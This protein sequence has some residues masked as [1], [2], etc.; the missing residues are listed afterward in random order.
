MDLINGKVKNLYYK[1][2]LASLGSALITS[3][4]SVVDMAVVGNYVGPNG[5]AALA[6][7]APIWNIIYSLGLLMGVGGSILFSSIRGRNIDSSNED[8]KYFTSSFIGSI[9]LAIICW[10]VFYLFDKPIL[11]FFGA[12]DETLLSLCESYLMPIKIVLPTYLI[13]QMLIA[14]LRNDNDPTLATFA[15]LFGGVFNVIGDILF[16]FTFNMGIFGAGLATAIGSVITTILLCIHFFKKKNT[17]K[18]I[19]IDKLFI[20][21]KNITINGFS[22]FFIDVAMGILTI[23][24]NRQI[25][26]YLDSNALS[27]YG[28]IINISTFVQCCAYGVGQAS[29]PIISTNYG[30]NNADRI[31]QTLKYALIT[32]LIFSIF[33][34]GISLIY[35][36]GFIYLFMTP[37]DEILK[38]GPNMIR[39]YALSFILLPLNI[40]STY[41]FQSIMK[42]KVS[43]I[44]SVG[45]GLVIS[46]ILIYLLPLISP[47]MI[48]FTMPITE[49]I[50]AIYAIIQIVRCTK[51]LEAK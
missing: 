29:Q 14:F 2:L 20:R 22:S 32:S 46:G 16:T 45:R 41:Y 7:I 50:I 43:F 37:T 5:T 42:P 10:I 28:P 51:K 15:V 12:S 4:Y 44:I 35:P 48:W 25:M 36:E 9:I 1:Y 3:I 39:I 49:V 24:F 13:N 19:K 30:A 33:W 21:L 34:T 31:K 11:A 38:I 8:N 47:D 40:F 6:I 23:L 26:R 18:L 17:L 27:I